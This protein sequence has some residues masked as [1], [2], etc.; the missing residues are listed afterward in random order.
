MRVFEGTRRRQGADLKGRR[1]RGREEVM[2]RAAEIR[3]D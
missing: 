3:M 1:G 2:W